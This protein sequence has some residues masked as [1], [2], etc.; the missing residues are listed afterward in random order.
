MTTAEKTG[1]QSG[2]SPLPITK[3]GTLDFILGRADL[4]AILTAVLGVC[5]LGVAAVVMAIIQLA[6]LISSLCSD[7]FDRWLIAAPALALLWVVL[8]GRKLCVF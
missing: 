8:R 5:M 4:I 2:M 1:S 3:G 7:S 6:R